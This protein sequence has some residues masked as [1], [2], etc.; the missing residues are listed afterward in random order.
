LG[1]HLTISSP[2]E[3]TQSPEIK[4]PGSFIFRGK[5]RNVVKFSSVI[6]T[7]P[8]YPFA[9][10]GRIANEVEQRDRITVIRATIGNPDKEAP[11]T[12]KDLMSKYL[13]QP[14]S[15]YGYP[16]DVYPKRGIPELVDAIINDY[17]HKYG[18]TL[19]AENIAVTGWAKR[20]P[21]SPGSIIRSGESPDSR[22]CISCL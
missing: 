20:G 19:S 22:P 18:V 4:N 5:R 1:G 21:S 12:L 9:K 17:R 7:I 10:I 14:G 2:V 16:F 6:N 8:E 11:W 3:K 15:T 13:L